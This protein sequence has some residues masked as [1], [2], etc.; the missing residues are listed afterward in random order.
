MRSSPSFASPMRWP[1]AE[2]ADVNAP[3]EFI[4][5]GP[6]AIIMAGL[7]GTNWRLDDYVARG[8]YSALKKNLKEKIAPADVI[9]EVKKSALRGRGGAGF[10][11]RFKGGFMPQPN[12]RGKKPLWKS[13]EREP[14]TVKERDSQ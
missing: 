3:R 6:D 12:T 1:A 10:S 8:G 7:N 11:N 14:G 4:D 13:H 5:Y 2:A 9:A